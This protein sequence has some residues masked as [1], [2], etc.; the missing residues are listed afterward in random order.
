MA[1]KVE[2]INGLLMLIH[3]SDIQLDTA[4]F[5]RK[6][7]F[8]EMFLV[9]NSQFLMSLKTAHT[10][11]NHYLFILHTH[12]AVP[13][14]CIIFNKKMS[15]YRSGLSITFW[16]YLIVRFRGEIQVYDFSKD[17]LTQGVPDICLSTFDEPSASNYNM[18]LVNPYDKI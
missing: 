7:L 10:G 9:L 12:S 3:L 1:L 5:Q 18:A 11:G 14:V 2:N 17:Q 8:L 15:L 16:H 6:N 4:D 13:S